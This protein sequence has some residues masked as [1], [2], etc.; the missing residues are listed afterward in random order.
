M[1]N[2]ALMFGAVCLCG[3]AVAHSILGER[4]LIGP[5][6]APATRSGMLA[7]SGYARLVLRFAWHLTSIAFVG[8]AAPLAVYAFAPVDW[9]ARL[10]LRL[11]AATS[12]AMGGVTLAISRGRHLAWPFFLGA[13]VAAL[14]V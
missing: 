4:W 12:I 7:R 8:L 2:P 10:M 5:L 3:L 11:V 1:L 13:G 9:T 14:S 6:T